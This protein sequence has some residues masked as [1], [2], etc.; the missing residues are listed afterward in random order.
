MNKKTKIILA[1]VFAVLFV[2]GLSLGLYFGLKDNPSETDFAETGTV[3][4]IDENT[5]EFSYFCPY[6][7]KNTKFE[8]TNENGFTVANSKEEISGKI[9]SSEYKRSEND[10]FKIGTLV[11]NIDLDKDLQEGTSYNAVLKENS[12]E[13]KK[14]KYVNRDITAS[15]SVAA[16]SDG[17]LDAEE[18]KYL[19]AKAVVLSDVEASLIKENGKAYFSI[20]AKA[21]GITQ[22]DETG[23][24][25]YQVYAGYSFKNE[26]GTKLRFLNENVEFSAENG[27]IT[28]KGETEKENL[29]PGMDYK[30]VIT[31]GF[32]TNDDKTVVNDEYKS[33]FTYVEQ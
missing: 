16:S 23:A 13:L 31:K 7:S 32:F 28:I 2:A 17:K 27:V 33:N 4:I 6:L 30:L 3:K 29:I 18:E 21:D 1:V 5:I 14:E 9:T 25:N 12:I 20:T 11:L 26:N 19:N 8:I 22:Y 24:K 10:S 15:F